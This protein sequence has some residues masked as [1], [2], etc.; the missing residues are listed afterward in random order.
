MSTKPR[1]N[2]SM[3]SSKVTLTRAAR[4][5]ANFGISPDLRGMPPATALYLWS[6]DLTSYYQ[7]WQEVWQVHHLENPALPVPLSLHLPPGQRLMQTSQRA[8]RHLYR[9]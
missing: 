8:R 7:Y 2:I 3:H 5:L 4:L 6:T 9:T 1:S